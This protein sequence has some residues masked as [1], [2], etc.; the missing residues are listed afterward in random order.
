MEVIN[1]VLI[2]VG[3][4]IGLIVLLGAFLTGTTTLPPQPVATDS[5]SSPQATTAEFPVA[6]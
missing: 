3:K 6:P 1:A 4:V 5:T 2:L